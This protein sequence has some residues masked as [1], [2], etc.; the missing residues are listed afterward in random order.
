MSGATT[1]FFADQAVSLGYVS[2]ENADACLAELER[3]RAS[4]NSAAE[5]STIMLDKGFVTQEMRDWIVGAREREKQGSASGSKNHEAGAA[6]PDAQTVRVQCANP[7]CAKTMVC[8]ADRAGSTGQC[9]QCGTRFQIPALA[10]GPALTQMLGD[11][12]LARKIGEGGMGSVYEALH[13][14]LKRKAALKVISRKAAQ[15]SRFLERF[16]REAQA[17]AALNH[18]NMVQVYDVGEDQGHHFIAMELVDGESLARRLKREGKIALGDALDIVEQI[19]KVLRYAYGQS[20][21]HRDIKPDNVLLSRDGQVKLAD[22]GIAKNIE[23]E[24]GVTMDGSALGTPHYMAP[25]QAQDARRVD[26][27]ADIYALGITLLHLLTGRVPYEGDSPY[28]IIT[29]HREEKLP[30]GSD[31]GT[32]LPAGAEALIRKMAAKDPAERYQDYDSL[33]A[34]LGAVKAGRNVGNSA[35]EAAGVTVSASRRR[36][37]IQRDP[38]SKAALLAVLGA[39]AALAIGVA[40]FLATRPGKQPSGPGPVTSIKPVVTKVEVPEGPKEEEPSAPSAQTE[41]AAQMLTYAESYANEHPEEYAKVVER[42]REVERNCK[43]TVEAMKAK[44][45]AEAWQRKWEEVAEAEFEKRRAAA[46]GAL[47][48]WKFQDAET[49]WEAFPE[50]LRA[51]SIAPKVEAELARIQEARR[52][53]AKALE[54]EAKPLLARKAEELSAEEARAVSGLLERAEKAPEGLPEEAAQAIEALAEKL[55]TCLED[56]EAAATLR[57]QEAFWGFWAKYESHMKRKAFDEALK[58]CESPLVV[59]PFRGA[60]EGEDDPLKRGTTN[61]VLKADA[62]LVKSLFSKA[63]ENLPTLVGKTILVAGNTMR[64]KEVK[65]GKLQLSGAGAEMA[66]DADRLDTGTLLQLG[67][68]GIEGAKPQARAKALHAFYYGKSSD[69][70]EALKEAAEA[71]ADVSFYQSRMVPVLVV[72]TTPSG[73]TVE[74]GKMVDGEWQMVDLPAGKAGEKTRTTPLRLEVEKN[75]THRVEIAKDGYQPVTEEVK[76][77]EAGEFRVSARLKKA[78]LPAYLIGLFEVLKESKDKYGNPIRKGADRKTG[79]PLEI[80]H[81]QTGMHFVFIP[82]GE[83]LMGSPENEKDRDANREGTGTQ[84][85]VHL[86]KPFYLGKYEVTQAEWKVVMD[87]N[88]SKFPGDRNPVDMVSWGDCQGF[89]KKLNEGFR[90]SPLQRAGREPTKAGHY[91][92]ALPTEA[93]WEYACRA[94]TQTR[95]YFGD[96]LD[97]RELADYAWLNANSGGKT[98]SVGEKKPNVWGLYD[99]SGNVWEWCEDWYGSYA[100]E[101]VS[102]PTGPERGGDRVFRGGSWG[103]GGRYCRSAFRYDNAPAYRDRHLGCRASLRSY[104]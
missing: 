92:L 54:D 83:F 10:K 56:Y 89:L 24:G 1:E 33:L 25:E 103:N 78:Q 20:I 34:D 26:H 30:T 69:A 5:L 16:Y 68:A 84:H 39:G 86:T 40:V 4:G 53:M 67:L 66:W 41:P 60:P 55:R 81:K 21:I 58:L 57:A 51:A 99:M 63:E 9:P 31:L 28:S 50:G 49:V 42:F 48:A 61:A 100:K 22:L 13:V 7:K 19:A 71:G 90:S 82:A 80:R 29:K 75:T 23:A 43:G 59:H 18:P 11:Y 15:N 101:A 95:F 65:D 91:K 17:T 76:I 8:P 94:G 74:V 36:R 79:M 47:K 72:T 73:A 38:K 27:R 6:G 46:A 97:Y 32:P 85:K 64:V 3:A 2:K 35:S 88:P 70:V 87:S 102:D 98:H 62:Q 104:P 52:G 44:D 96:D 12:R 37:A 77:G 14:K 93:Q 45:T